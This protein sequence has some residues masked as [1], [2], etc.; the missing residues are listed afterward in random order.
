VT[1]IRR[2]RLKDFALELRDFLIERYSERGVCSRVE[3][4]SHR[5]EY[6]LFHDVCLV[7]DWS[8]AVSVAAWHHV[9]LVARVACHHVSLLA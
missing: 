3:G 2:E 7:C 6:L 5:D 1:P 4:I 8:V 9:S